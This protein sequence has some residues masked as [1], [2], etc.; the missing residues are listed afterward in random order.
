VLAEE[1]SPGRERFP[2]ALFG[3]SDWSTAHQAG[4]RSIP[5]AA[6]LDGVPSWLAIFDNSR[7]AALTNMLIDGRGRQPARPGPDPASFINPRSETGPVVYTYAYTMVEGKTPE[8]MPGV[9]AGT[10]AKVVDGCRSVSADTVRARLLRADAGRRV[11]RQ[12]GSSR[13]VVHG[14]DLTLALG[15][16]DHRLAGRD[17]RDGSHPR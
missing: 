1:L 16:E 17:R 6:A 2:R 3:E 9:L 10:F 12:A 5:G 11:R 7:S 4:G 8:Q 14:L 15:R 13:A